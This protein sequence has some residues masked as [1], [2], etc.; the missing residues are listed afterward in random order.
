MQNYTLRPPTEADLPA[1]VD[2]E[3]EIARISFQDDAI[4]DPEVHR[5]KLA[6]ALERDREGMFVAEDK[7]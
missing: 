1:I 3:I 5:K 2:F 4:T 7:A 6:K